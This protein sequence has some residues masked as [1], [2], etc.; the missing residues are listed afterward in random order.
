VASALSR[1]GNPTRGGALVALSLAAG[2]IYGLTAYSVSQ[3]T[4]EIGIRMALG[5]EQ[6]VVVTMMLKH[7]ALALG[8]GGLIGV[9]G[10]FAL[11]Y[12]TSS[13]MGEVDPSDPVVYFVV[14]SFLASVA[15]LASYLPA[16]RV[17]RVDPIV[18]LRA[19]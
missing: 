15:F 8:V 12:L 17:L 16:R 14:L 13:A 2:G 6:R 7:A 1:L 19:E 11:V 10:G 18:A 9:I 5:A 4:C 3:R